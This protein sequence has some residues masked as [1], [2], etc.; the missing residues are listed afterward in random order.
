MCNTFPLNIQT[1][2]IGINLL[3]WV[4]RKQKEKSVC[5]PNKKTSLKQIKEGRM[6]FWKEVFY[7]YIKGTN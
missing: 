6:L 7:L 1:F 3:N 4:E 5:V 2:H